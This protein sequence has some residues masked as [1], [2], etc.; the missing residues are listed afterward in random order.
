M[1]TPNFQDR[2]FVQNVKRFEG[3]YTIVMASK[4]TFKEMQEFVSACRADAVPIS[5]P[6]WNNLLQFVRRL[7]GKVEEER[8]KET[9]AFL[10]SN[11]RAAADH[12]TSLLKRTPSKPMRPMTYA[13]CLISPTWEPPGS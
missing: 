7:E 3:T 10:E 1:K 4:N 9:L 13:P 6:K 5:P 12:L 8:M 2:D 11:R